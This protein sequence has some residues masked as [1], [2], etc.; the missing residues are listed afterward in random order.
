M[1]RKL[2]YLTLVIALGWLAGCT[3][4]PT[5]DPVNGATSRVVTSWNDTVLEVQRYAPGYRPPA[6]AR[7]L[8]YVNLAAYEAAAPSFKTYQSIAPHFSALQLPTKPS[9]SINY[10]L[11]VNQVYFNLFNKF[12]PHIQASDKAK[13]QQTY[14]RLETEINASS[15]VATR[16]KSWGDAVANAVWAWAE[17][18]ALGNNYYKDA[19]PASYTPPVGPGLW[20][21]TDYSRALFPRWGE[22]R[23]FAIN[24]QDKDSSP[25]FPRYSTSTSSEWYRQAKEVYDLT[26]QNKAEFQWIAEFWSDDI[27]TQTFEPASRWLAISSQ[28]CKKQNA[29]LETALVTNAKVSMSMTDVAIMVWYNKY[30]YNINRPVSYINDN[31]DNTWETILINRNSGVGNM[32]PPF[33]AYPSGHAGFGAA[34]AEALSSVFGET[35]AMTDNC[36]LGRTEFNGTPRSF[37]SFRQMADENAISRLYLGVHYRLDAEEGLRLG[38]LAGRKINALNWK[39]SGI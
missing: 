9:G 22:V 33:P 32:T 20:R 31:W 1:L 18:D 3:E 2:N 4:T 14:N 28:V 37:V 8:G 5:V 26:K 36:H 38:Y 6:A 11:A 29:S 35:Y 13:I 19:Q 23:S 12:Y 17:S 34:A 25:A 16:S 21:Q 15:D 27:F 24:Q 7:M 30:K 10:E 39:K